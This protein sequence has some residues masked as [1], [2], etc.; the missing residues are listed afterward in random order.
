MLRHLGHRGGS[1]AT[2]DAGFK[3]TSCGNTYLHSTTTNRIRIGLYK[4]GKEPSHDELLYV[5]TICFTICLCISPDLDGAKDL[6][7]PSPPRP[8]AAKLRPLGISHHQQNQNR[9]QRV[10]RGR[11]KRKEGS[12]RIKGRKPGNHKA[13]PGDIQRVQH[14]QQ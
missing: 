13:C 6:I 11:E 14:H 9:G 7:P 12:H 10:C 3:V 5:C 4:T 1:S 2:T 8:L